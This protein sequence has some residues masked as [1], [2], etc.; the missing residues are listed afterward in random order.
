MI[1]VLRPDH[2]DDVA[3]LDLPRDFGLKRENVVELAVE[4]LAPQ[5]QSV[6]RTDEVG[7]DANPI[8]RRPDARPQQIVRGT[9]S[10]GIALFGQLL[11][12]VRAEYDQLGVAPDRLARVLPDAGNQGAVPFIDAGE[13][14]DG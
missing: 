4:A 10:R 8:A 3:P 13:R 9:P 7:T 5:L 14:Q 12:A 1:T 2:D 11:G 6:F